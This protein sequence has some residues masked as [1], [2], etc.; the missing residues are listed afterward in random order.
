LGKK[1]DAR[2]K[3]VFDAIRW[4]MAPVSEHKREIGFQLG[5]GG[6]PVCRSVIIYMQ[7]P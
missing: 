5:E 4:L 3:M 1:Y 7:V 6:L 2:F